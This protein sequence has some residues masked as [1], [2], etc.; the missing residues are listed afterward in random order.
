MTADPNLAE[1]ETR[2]EK[3]VYVYGRGRPQ[4]NVSVMPSAQYQL[5]DDLRTLLAEYRRRREV[6]E[7]IAVLDKYSGSSLRARAAS[8]IARQALGGSDA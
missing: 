4:G 5:S 2:L 7:K 6:L 3:L 8:E 1:V